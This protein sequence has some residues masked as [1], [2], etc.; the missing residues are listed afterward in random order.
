MFRR[1]VSNLSFS[2]ALVGQLGFYAKRLR[3][4]ETTRRIGL[5]FTALALVVQY[6]AVFS[7]PESANASSANSFV[8]GGVKN[9]SE[10]VKYYDKNHNNIRDL[11]NSLGITKNELES[12]KKQTVNSKGVYSWGLQSRFSKSQ[13]EG[14]YTVNKSGEN[15][16]TR[17]FYYRPLSLWDTG[18][19]VKNGS[20]YTMFVGKSSKF[21]W[22]A[23]IDICGNLVTK[24]PPAKPECPK[25]TVGVYPKC[26][27]PPSARCDYLKISSINNTHTFKAR[28]V[29]ANE[30]TIKSYQYTV[31][32]NGSVVHTKTN[33]S[34]AETNEY[35]YSQNEVGNYTVE[36]V[37]KTSLGDKTGSGCIK[38]FNVTAPEV[39]AVNPSL[40]KDDPMCQP[41]PGD[42]SLWIKDEKCASELVQT[43]SAKNGS[44]G[45]VDASTVISKENDRITYLLTVENTG[46][47]ETTT[48]I[49]ELLDDV[50]EY[51]SI[52]DS[53]GGALNRDKKTLS[54]TNIKLAPKEKQTRAFTIQVS[55]N[56]SAMPQGLDDKDSFNCVMTNTF[57]N[58][59]QIPV[60]C[61]TP[62]IVESIVSEMPKTGPTEN[63]IFAGILISVVAYFYARSRQL[64]TEVRLI[65]RD[66][67]TGTI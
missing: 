16:G 51:A 11:F 24:T 55:E 29:T 63:M 49:H 44:Q 2:P 9:I 45:N 31:K 37:V 61:P 48:D 43:K 66:L 5:I 42:E 22:F 26:T 58:T 39:C 67:N 59:V 38:T 62:K 30:A 50:S 23:I 7:P 34:S 56:I 65:R 20:N 4:E 36:L 54:W 57:G 46:L 52:I 10:F 14:S 18:S 33:A 41:C 32:K 60:K 40:S 47:L 21:G 64:K 15:K 8:S 3:K 35:T 6:F 19:N 27:Q 53:G 17:N 28:A 1:I 12:A 13:G 25:G